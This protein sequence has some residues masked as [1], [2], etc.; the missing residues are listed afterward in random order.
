MKQAKLLL[1]SLFF[2][3]LVSVSQEK[4]EKQSYVGSSKSNKYHYTSCE[5]TKK[6]KS[7]NLVTFKTVAEAKKAKYVACKVCKPPTKD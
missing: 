2:I 7:D 5:W 6:I 1:R 3:V 4:T